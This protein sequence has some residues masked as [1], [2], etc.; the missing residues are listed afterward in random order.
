MEQGGVGQG[1]DMEFQKQKLRL[2]E[3]RILGGRFWSLGRE[4]TW[5]EVPVLHGV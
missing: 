3:G 5:V 1:R 4:D 2:W